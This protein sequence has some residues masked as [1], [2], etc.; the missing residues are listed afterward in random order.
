MI[1]LKKL[2]LFIISILYI[3]VVGLMNNDNKLYFI[4]FSPVNIKTLPI[5]I[6]IEQIFSFSDNYL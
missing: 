3:K 4:P 6:Y 5:V 2:P 1:L